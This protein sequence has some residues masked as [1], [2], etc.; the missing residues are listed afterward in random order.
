M[1]EHQ[2]NNLPV[3]SGYPNCYVTDAGLS[4]NMIKKPNNTILHMTYTIR[5]RATLLAILYF[6][7]YI[8]LMNHRASLRPL[9]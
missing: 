8:R 2:T 5:E 9:K 1:A 6:K 4:Q 7:I 3:P